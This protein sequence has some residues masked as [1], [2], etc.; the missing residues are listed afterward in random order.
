[1]K[2]PARRWPPGILVTALL[3]LGVAPGCRTAHPVFEPG[4]VDQGVAVLERPLPGDMAALYRLRVPSSGGLRMSVA[5]CGEAGR[6]TISEPFGAAVSLLAWDGT[7]WSRLYDFDEGCFLAGTD[8]AAVV[9]VARLPYPHLVRLLGGRLPVGAGDEIE[10]GAHG[11]VVRGDGWGAQVRMA[12]DPWR[13][14]EVEAL[15]GSDGPGWRV[16]LGEHTSSL[17][18]LVRLQREG[19]A[20]GRA[21]AGEAGVGPGRRP[22]AAAADGAVRGPDSRRRGRLVTGSGVVNLEAAAKVNLHLEVLGRRPDGYHEVRTLLQSI[23]L[24]DS[25]SVEVDPSGGLSLGVEPEG[26][27]SAGDDNLVLRAAEALRRQTGCRL[28][29]RFGLTKRI[30]VGAGLGGGSADAAA[31]LVALNRLWRVHLLQYELHELAAGLGSDV[32]FFLQGGLALGVGRG[33]EIYP[34]P[35][36]PRLGVLVVMPEISVSTAAVYGRFESGQTWRSP[37]PRVYAL[38][39]GLVAAVP[40]GEFV[41]DLQS[42]VVET[43][44]EVAEALAALESS[45]PRLAAMTGSGSA[46]FAVF[47]GPEEAAVVANGLEG[48]WKVHVG[49]TTMRSRSWAPAGRD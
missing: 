23:D 7:R 48:T 39:A 17:P 43:W 14:L 35:D 24:C 33:E 2:I 37:D 41:N 47:D 11:V 4:E 25:L 18:G 31:A 5:T 22:A 42:V 26:V 44:P 12:S 49:T 38:S 32:P 46:V 20:V 29:A 36:L 6:L 30:P 40:W 28:G 13:V 3:A 10:A 16:E 1:M 27:V 8:L 34:L 21:S 9:G 15:D 45:R 19:G